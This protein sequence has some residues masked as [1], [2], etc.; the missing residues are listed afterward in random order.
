VNSK[1]ILVWG[2]AFV[3]IIVLVLLAF[4]VSPIA[5]STSLVTRGPFLVTVDEDGRTRLRDRYVLMAPIA[6]RMDRTTHRVGDRV[7]AGEVLVRISPPAPV[8]LDERTRAEAEARVAAAR[9]EL[10][11]A[12]EAQNAAA[13]ADE[14]ARRELEREVALL[15]KGSGRESDVDRARNE[16]RRAAAQLRSSRFALDVARYDLRAAEAA[17]GYPT[18]GNGSGGSSPAVLELAAP[19]AGVVL[20]RFRESAGFVSMGESLVEIGDPTQIEVV[21]DVL[22]ADAVRIAQGAKVFLERWGTSRPLEAIVSIIEPL[23]FTKISALGVEEERVNVIA[24]L[25][26][27]RDEWRG[28]GAGY[29]VGARIVVRDE[30]EVLQ[31]PSS[32][33][34][35][36][37]DGWAVFQLDSASRRVA[38]R[39][40]VPGE[41][42][43]LTVEILSGLEAG[44]LVVVHAPSALE[45]GGEIV[46]ASEGSR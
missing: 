29:R 25:I 45:D 18:V 4:R 34:H 16:S 27:P 26:S 13:S 41:W 21:V 19:I 14:L 9:A 22:T 39:V 7:E 40:V 23:G 12:E 46:E 31:A 36:F 35:R 2:G 30:A 17:A 1:R 43:G 11:R 33:L 8:A 10:S 6:G 42:N 5:V 44:D 15:D 24:D 3:L 38:R 20:A 28:L 32:A 37:A